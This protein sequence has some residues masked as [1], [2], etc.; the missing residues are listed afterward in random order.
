[1]YL[2]SNFPFFNSMTFNNNDKHNTEKDHEKNEYYM[3][4]GFD[5][6]GVEKMLVL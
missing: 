2:K 3:F 1:M 4:L 5:S 6:L